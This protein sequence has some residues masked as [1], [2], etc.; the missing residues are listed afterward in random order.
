MRILLF[1][2]AGFTFLGGL[3]ILFGAKSAIHEIEAFLLFIISIISISGA[4]IVDAVHT[5]RSDDKPT[6]ETQVRCTE[7]REL[8][9]KEARLCKHCGTKHEKSSDFDD[10]GH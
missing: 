3:G 2:I 1:L 10:T 4:G 5:L 8:I 6:P 9:L 7:C